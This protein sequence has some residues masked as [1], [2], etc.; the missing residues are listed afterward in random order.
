MTQNAFK[1]HLNSIQRSPDLL[2]A[3]KRT[4]SQREREAR[5]GTPIP[6]S[7]IGGA[8]TLLERK[9]II[10]FTFEKNRPTIKGTMHNQ[11]SSNKLQRTKGGEKV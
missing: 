10:I 8:Y 2:V 4:D 5:E 9:G 1:P 11:T 7:A 3:F 6:G